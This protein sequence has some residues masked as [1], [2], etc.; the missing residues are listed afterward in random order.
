MGGVFRAVA[1][2][3]KG[4]TKGITGMKK[5][6]KRQQPEPV[7][8]KTATTAKTTQQR[9][10]ALGSGYGTSGQTIMTGTGGVEEQ[11]R[12]GRTLLGGG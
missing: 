10:A 3:F 8:P 1:S 4:V 11:A 9:K 2:V 5:K 12:T 7:Q 6:Q